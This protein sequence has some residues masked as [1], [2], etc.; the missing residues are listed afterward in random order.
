MNNKYLERELKENIVD[1]EIFECQTY[2][3]L[4]NIKNFL[5]QNQLLTEV[6]VEFDID[7][8]KNSTLL[9]L[10]PYESQENQLIWNQF[11]AI[12]ILKE[13]NNQLN[14]ANNSDIEEQEHLIYN[15]REDGY[16]NYKKR[17]PTIDD[18]KKIISKN[19]T[20]IRLHLLLKW[21]N[22]K[23]LY[24]TVVEYLTNNIYF[25]TMIYSN[26]YFKEFE[27]KDGINYL[28]FIKFEEGYYINNQK[29][30]KY[31]KV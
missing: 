16:L 7:K 8:I 15:E 20:P 12:Q 21:T 22:D 9:H 3:D 4:D 11:V 31:E 26:S 24:R 27:T 5:K 6:I 2:H 17:I 30:K 19:K 28:R 1:C 14:I 10:F 13:L 29:V 18:V 25:N 23:D